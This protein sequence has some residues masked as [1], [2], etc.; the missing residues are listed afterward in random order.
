VEATAWSF[1]SARRILATV[2]AGATLAAP[3]VAADPAQ[4]SAVRYLVAA[5]NAD[6]GMPAAPGEGA[7]SASM[8][9]WTAI[10][11][12]A[13]G[14]D[15]REVRS[16]G[17]VTLADFVEAAAPAANNAGDIE[18][19]LIALAACRLPP[20]PGLLARLASHHRA[21][22]SYDG[23]VNTTT[24]AILGLRAAGRAPSALRSSARWLASQ[25]NRDGGFGFGVR[26][27]PSDADDTGAA[28]EA[29]AA[30]G[31]T[32]HSSAVRRAAHWLAGHQR[33]DGGYAL[34]PGVPSN[35]QSTAFAVQGLVAA[36]R[37]PA[38]LHRHGSRSP[39]GFLRSLAG[40]GGAVNYSRTS[41]QTPVWVTAQALAALARRPLPVLP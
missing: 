17:G 16:S 34:T 1:V 9:D 39:I 6:G 3:A 13:A 38:K 7:S 12:A 5:Q 28:L 35:A 20:Q 26:G 36:R 11:L 22:G 21:D 24:F 15:P 25:Q 18:R 37:N 27:T 41:R 19:T 40:P 10:G 2:V 31:R 23:R 4:Q 29:L 8:S 32:S 14:R 30:A 33:S